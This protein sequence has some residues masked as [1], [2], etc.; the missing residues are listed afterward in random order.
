MKRL[1]PVALL[2]MLENWLSGCF[3]FVK[4]YDSHSSVFNIRSGVRQGL[5]LSPYLFSIYIDDVGKLCV[6]RNR[7]FV[8]LYADDILLIN[9][10]VSEVQ[11]LVTACEKVLLAL[12]MSLNAG[13][14]CCMHIGSRND[15]PCA[16]VCTHDDR[17]LSWVN[18]LRYLGIFM[19]SS[20][21]FK[22]SLNHAKRSFYR[23]ANSIFGKIGRIAS[24][25][26]LIE[27][28]KTKCMPI[29]LYGFEVCNLCKK[30]LSSLDFVVN[31][32]FMKLFRTSDIS[33]L[34]VE[35][36]S[37]LTCPVLF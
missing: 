32:F 19:V 12:D 13:K 30:D 20:S 11:S 18:E 7:S 8:L 10:S 31:R 26:V 21:S 33:V 15:K 23:V 27:L 35:K 1:I 9:S 6:F 24:K 17:Q 3:A 5:V 36:C 37:S 34:T 28:L 29:L 16:N 4:W 22:C 14:S 2:E 25:D